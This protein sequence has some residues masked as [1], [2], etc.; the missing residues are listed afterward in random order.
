MLAKKLILAIA[1]S[2]VSLGRITPDILNINQEIEEIFFEVESYQFDK[3]FQKIDNLIKR[4]NKL[5][6]LIGE[7]E[8]LILKITQAIALGE[9][10]ILY[11]WQKDY[12]KKLEQSITYP[13]KA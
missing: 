6:Y 3:S 9:E 13:R 10:D 12:Q 7:A 2:T 5:D 11:V 8:L 4:C 1:L